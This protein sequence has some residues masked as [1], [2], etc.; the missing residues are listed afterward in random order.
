MEMAPLTDTAVI[1]V[2]WG[3]FEDTRQCIDSLLSQNGNF[4]IILVDNGTYEERLDQITQLSS[5]VRL[6]SHEQNLGFAEG[7]NKAIK[8]AE[9]LGVT[10]IL[11][12]NNDTVVSPDSLHFLFDCQ[13]HTNELVSPLQSDTK[14][15]VTSVSGRVLKPWYRPI[16][17]R[18]ESQSIDFLSGYCLLISSR[19]FQEIGYFDPIYFLYYEDVDFCTRAKKHGF[20]L[21]KCASV[22]VLHKESLS[23]IPSPEKVYYTVRNNLIYIQKYA[24]V[25]EKPFAYGYLFLLVVKIILSHHSFAYTA[26]SI[27]A[28]LDFVLRIG[29]KR[30]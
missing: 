24:R 21:K 3:R 20:V 30:P 22:K 23:G 12:L 13:R 16:L 28:V 6:V 17:T 26:G 29:G 1:V 11:L 7:N 15:K 10:R 8:I 9:S 18:K 2:H 14:G 4:H 19:V 27:L 5:R 25:L